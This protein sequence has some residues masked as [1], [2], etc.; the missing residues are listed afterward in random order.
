MEKPK[1]IVVR[2]MGKKYR[3]FDTYSLE[4]PDDT[5]R[6]EKETYDNLVIAM[7]S[8]AS[9]LAKDHDV[10]TSDIMI[11]PSLLSV[12]YDDKKERFEHL[13]QL[14]VYMYVNFRVL[15]SMIKQLLLF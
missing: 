4:I 8:L 13:Y 1:D 12:R 15:L 6:V 10:E 7:T 14:D 5:Q 2:F 11:S 3:Y 9:K